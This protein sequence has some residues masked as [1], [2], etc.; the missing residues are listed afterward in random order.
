MASFIDPFGAPEILVD[1]VAYREWVGS[2][3]IR[4]GMFACEHGE[5]ILRLKLVMAARTCAIE[6]KLT[7]AMA[8]GVRHA[9]LLM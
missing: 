9:A 2:E 1:G 3:F 6:S 7:E 5:H 4:F 8:A